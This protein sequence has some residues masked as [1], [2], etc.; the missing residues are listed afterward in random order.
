[1]NDS[2]MLNNIENAILEKYSEIR[3]GKILSGIEEV[4][5]QLKFENP[6]LAIHIKKRM[7]D[8]AEKNGDLP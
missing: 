1:M 2:R 8:M 5:R 6:E 3:K 4:Y 7:M